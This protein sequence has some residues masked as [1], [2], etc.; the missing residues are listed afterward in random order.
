MGQME[1]DGGSRRQGLD[2]AR[3]GGAVEAGGMK[4]AAT[5][6]DQVAHPDDAQLLRRQRRARLAAK[7]ARNDRNEISRGTLGVLRLGL[8][9]VGLGFL[10]IWLHLVYAVFLLVP[11]VVCLL[12]PV[13]SHAVTGWRALKLRGELAA[14]PAHR[15]YE[16]GQLAALGCEFP[17]LGAL[18]HAAQRAAQLIRSS[19][20]VKRGM[21][22]V[23]AAEVDLAVYELV[24]QVFNPQSLDQRRAL[25]EA[26]DSDRLAGL[27]AARAAELA[28]SNG[29]LRQQ[30]EHLEAVAAQA[31][32][33]SK[34]LA[35]WDWANRLTGGAGDNIRAQISQ[36][37]AAASAEEMAARARGAREFLERHVAG[38]TDPGL[39]GAGKMPPSGDSATGGREPERRAG[40]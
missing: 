33:Q 38:I 40:A 18:V 2:Q 27:V 26:A 1:R 37:R 11:G 20:A 22:A 35:D 5:D 17:Q 8:F 24:D 25:R 7:R 32:A 21:L 3:E 30:V 15:V 6:F 29:Q 39:G 4:W 34:V 19:A 10:G 12:A 13:V 31:Q 14:S 36:E 28:I 23:S 9:G 16:P